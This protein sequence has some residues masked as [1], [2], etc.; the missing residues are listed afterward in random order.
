[1]LDV[2][3]LDVFC[4]LLV[5]WP[6]G[7]ADR[8][9]YAALFIG[10]ARDLAAPEA[11]ILAAALELLGI[12]SVRPGVKWLA[13]CFAMAGVVI[14][15]HLKSEV[16]RFGRGKEELALASEEPIVQRALD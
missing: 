10:L 14:A 8:A 1:M 11:F 3:V 16:V 4:R 13:V 5:A 2:Q 7:G 15:M 6:F 9:P 12:R